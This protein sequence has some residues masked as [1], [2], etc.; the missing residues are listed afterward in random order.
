MTLGFGHSLR[1]IALVP[2]VA[3]G[4]SRAP[5]SQI[6]HATSVH[7]FVP[8]ALVIVAGYLVVLLILVVFGVCMGWQEPGEGGNGGGGPHRPPVQQPTPPGGRQLSGDDPQPALVD[9]FAAWEGQLRAADE[10]TVPDRREDVQVEI[11]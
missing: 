3:T 6:S 8:N 5:S 9:D 7:V 2:H 11:T 1:T 10:Q 4:L